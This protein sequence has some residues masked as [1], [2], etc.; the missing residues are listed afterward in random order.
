MQFEKESK[1][2][3]AE[4]DKFSNLFWALR[5]QDELVRRPKESKRQKGVDSPSKNDWMKNTNAQFGYGEI[6]RVSLAATHISAGLPEQPL[7]FTV[8]PLHD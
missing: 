1:R 5:T 4:V 6:T 8:D 7:R 3:Y 2:V